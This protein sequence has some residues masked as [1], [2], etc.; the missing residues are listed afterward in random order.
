MEGEE[1]KT[2]L[3]RDQSQIMGKCASRVLVRMTP[4]T[5]AF[6]VFALCVRLGLRQYCTIQHTSMDG[7]TR[8]RPL[9]HTTT[10]TYCISTSTSTTYRVYEFKSEGTSSSRKEYHH[11]QHKV[12]FM[13]ASTKHT[14]MYEYQVPRRR[15]F[16]RD[17]PTAKHC[18]NNAG[19][20]WASTT[21]PVG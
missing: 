20:C 12:Q 9:P 11:V 13:S 16:W 8:L 15:D 4:V 1:Q 7:D 3:A 2:G 17:S 6:D 10:S 5:R 21:L 18:C 14:G 19:G